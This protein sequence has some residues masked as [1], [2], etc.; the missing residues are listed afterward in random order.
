MYK[1][2]RLF[3]LFESIAFI[4]ASLIHLGVLMHG[5]EHRPAGIA[6]GVI[7][8]ILLIGLVLTGMLA[9]W[10][11][12]IGIAVQAFALLG[13]CIGIYTIA[14]GIGPRTVPDIAFHIAIVIALL[15]GLF[16]T[17]RAQNQLA[18]NAPHR[19]PQS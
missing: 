10:T 15:S 16:V 3:L 13:T 14:I 4:T 9:T 6:E 17:V 2:I 12:G 5:H 8:T 19:S 11:R 1:T 18:A 7:G